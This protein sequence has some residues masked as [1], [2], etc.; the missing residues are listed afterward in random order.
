MT[1]CKKYSVDLVIYSIE[2]F[3]DAIIFMNETRRYMIILYYNRKDHVRYQSR[4]TE[5]SSFTLVVEQRVSHHLQDGY[6]M[7]EAGDGRG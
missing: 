7:A 6:Q 5:I 4:T 1:Y 3:D 2:Q